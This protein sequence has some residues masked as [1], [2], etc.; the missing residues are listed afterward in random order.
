MPSSSSPRTSS[1]RACPACRTGDTRTYLEFVADQRL[2][3]LGL[4]K[5]F[6]VEEP[7]L[8]HGAPG[9]AGALELLR[10]HRVGLPGRRRG[11]RRLRRG[12]LAHR[13]SPSVRRFG[14]GPPQ[15]T[16]MGGPRH[17]R[18]GN[19]PDGRSVVSLKHGAAVPRPTAV[20]RMQRPVDG[21]V[22]PG[23]VLSVVRRSA[24]SLW[25]TVLPAPARRRLRAS[26]PAFASAAC[27][28]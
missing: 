12:L 9:R 10:A 7:V 13:T 18:T 21:R 14:V 1:V 22:R 3:Q 25:R 11:R 28:A 23:G 8:L 4:P 20:G 16:R 26:Q 17:A 2:A 5:R 19:P 6:G 24:R 27:A 15:A